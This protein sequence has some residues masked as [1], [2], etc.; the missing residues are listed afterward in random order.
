M[1]ADFEKKIDELV[2]AKLSLEHEL[3]LTRKKV[4]E[5]NERCKERN[6]KI[7]TLEKEIQTQNKNHKAA[8]AKYDE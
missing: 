1:R 6:K 3:E 4:T 5:S 7:K 8:C 2:A